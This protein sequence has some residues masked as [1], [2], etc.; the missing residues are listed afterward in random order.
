MVLNRFAKDTEI[1]DSVVPEFLLQFLTGWTQIL[2]VFALCL[3]STPYFVIV[4][5]PMMVMFVRLFRQFA[6]IQQ[7]DYAHLIYKLI[8]VI[9]ACRL[10]KVPPN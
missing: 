7:G 1:V 5:V 8:L 9:H 10:R 6:N 2:S 4:M 3:W